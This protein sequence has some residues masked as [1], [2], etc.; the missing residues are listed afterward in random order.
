MLIKKY[1]ILGL[2]ILLSFPSYVK[3]QDDLPSIQFGI[4]AGPNLGWI[5]PDAKSYSSEGSVIGFNWGFITEFNI[6]SNY[7][8]NTGFNVAYNNGKLKYP[9][10]QDSVESILQRKYNLQY[11]EIPICLKMRTKQIGYITYYGKIGL[12]TSFN[13]RAKSK[14]VFN[15]EA[16]TENNIQDDITFMRESLIVGAGFQYSLGGSTFLLF[17]IVFNNGFSDILNGKNTIDTTIKENAISN[18]IEF[19]L[20]VLF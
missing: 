4:K 13:L 18:Y 3:G 6:S 20:G 14:D 7:A 1:I 10:V 19:N 12:G 11:L 17:E 5:K 8:I 2:V 9:Y 16:E 15:V